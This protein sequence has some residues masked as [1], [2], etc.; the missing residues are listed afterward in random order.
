MFDYDSWLESPYTSPQEGHT[1]ECY[2]CEG[3][4]RLW[5]KDIERFS[6]TEP[7]PNCEDGEVECYDDPREC[8]GEP[9]R[10]DD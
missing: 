1:H 5:L 10:D 6:D 3:Q 8:W 9:D 2:E 7:C 4:G